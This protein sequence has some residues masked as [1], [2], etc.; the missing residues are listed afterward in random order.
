MNK[1]VV[2]LAVAV[3]LAGIVAGWFTAN[4]LL[5][6][7]AAIDTERSNTV[8]TI[9]TVARENEQTTTTKTTET[10][11][12]SHDGLPVHKHVVT[13]ELDVAETTPHATFHDFPAAKTD[14][15]NATPSGGNSPRPA[16]GAV[17]PAQNA[18]MDNTV[19]IISREFMPSALTVPVG[20]KVTWTSRESESHTVTSDTGLFNGVINTNGSF[21][22]TFA[23]AGV[24]KYHCDNRPEMTGTIT[25]K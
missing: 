22:F 12:H 9:R 8:K 15:P 17:T 2:V 23:E 4:N 14:T 1:R 3:S 6:A 11:V 5:P 25:V 10:V 21:S 18:S 20:A 24:Y 16:D 19:L 7:L 13:V